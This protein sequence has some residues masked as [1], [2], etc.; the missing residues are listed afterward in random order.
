MQ[1]L[2]NLSFHLAGDAEEA[3]NLIRTQAKSGGEPYLA[4]LV[5]SNVLVHYG[6]KVIKYCLE[7]LP[8]IPLVMIEEMKN[9]LD[10]TVDWR[11]LGITR[12]LA[13][14]F[15]IKEIKEIAGPRLQSVYE[16]GEIWQ[17]KDLY[18]ESDNSYLPIRIDFF[19]PGNKSL[20]DLY[21]KIGESKFLKLFRTEDK[22]E[23]ERLSKYAHKDLKHLY[24]LKEDQQK[25]LK[26]C[27]VI[28]KMS[29]TKIRW[30]CNKN[31]VTYSTMWK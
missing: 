25:Y 12:H 19:I 11:K 4:I 5:S 30:A 26:Y 20:F 28:T 8:S 14:P 22:L 17:E 23:M 7:H 29:C 24:I 1:K 13:K 9:N 6:I 16:G 3:E 10:Q 27:E 2:K 18:L 21:V 31:S 15:G